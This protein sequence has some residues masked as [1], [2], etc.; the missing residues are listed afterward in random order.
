MSIIISM[1]RGL[2][3][4]VIQKEKEKQTQTRQIKYNPR[5]F[6]DLA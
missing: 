5:Y 2:L 1:M 4:Q 3:M 6:K